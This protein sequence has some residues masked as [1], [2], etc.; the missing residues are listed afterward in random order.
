MFTEASLRSHALNARTPYPRG[1]WDSHLFKSRKRTRFQLALKPGPLVLPT[2]IDS[3]WLAGSNGININDRIPQRTSN[4]V[5]HT[6]V[7]APRVAANIV[8][9]PD[10]HLART[11]V[12]VSRR[13]TRD[14]VAG[15]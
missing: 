3:C 7:E 5:G 4:S 6:R 1:V 12:V 14:P 2:L 15:A 13:L 9:E 8:V 10:K 11:A